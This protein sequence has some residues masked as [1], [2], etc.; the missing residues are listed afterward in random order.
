MANGGNLVAR[1]Y[2]LE[3]QDRYGNSVWKAADPA[4]TLKTMLTA[5]ADGLITDIIAGNTD[6]SQNPVW[7]QRKLIA[8]NGK[9]RPATFK[10]GTTDNS[11]DLAAFGYLAPPKNPNAPLLVTGVWT[12]NSDATPTT[13]SSISAA[14]GVWQS[15]FSEISALLPIA[16][17]TRPDT[18]QAVVIDAQSGELP[19]AC[20]KFTATEYY[21]PGTAPTTA[22]SLF[23][24]VTID[25]VSELLWGNGCSGSAQDTYVLDLGLAER[26]WPTWQAANLEWAERAR[27]GVGIVGG[28]REGKTDYFYASYWRP[29]GE[30]WGGIIAP[31]SYCGS[32]AP[33]PTPSIS[34][35]PSESP[36]DVPTDLPSPTP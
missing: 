6:A 31:T 24:S 25:T 35:M 23:R 22:C 9:R 11:K 7:A 33:T 30:S 28:A 10:T 36:S 17:F 12:G 13:A 15:Y 32:G 21:I 3:I 8:A 2:I 16:S 27:Q 19:G 5:D 29:Y 14:G 1:R 4:S 20:T 18:L 34:T 26:D